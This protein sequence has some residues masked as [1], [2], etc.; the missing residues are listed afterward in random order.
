M[1]SMWYIASTG[2]KSQ[3]WKRL[4]DF[5]VQKETIDQKNI[6]HTLEREMTRRPESQSVVADPT[7]QQ[8]DRRALTH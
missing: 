5:V 8:R 1:C 2:N 4:G 3:L 6:A 7:Q